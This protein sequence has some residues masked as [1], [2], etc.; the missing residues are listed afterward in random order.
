MLKVAN[1]ENSILYSI[2]FVCNILLIR[3]QFLKEMLITGIAHELMV[4][5]NDWLCIITSLHRKHT[6]II[7][8]LNVVK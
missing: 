2:S 3:Y 6:C 7:I 1:Y 5:L 8:F 4:Q